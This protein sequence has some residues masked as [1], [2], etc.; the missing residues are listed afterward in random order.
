MIYWRLWDFSLLNTV[1]AKNKRGG[2]FNNII[3]M[4]DTETSKSRKNKLVDGKWDKVE[5]YVVAWSVGFI[6][7]GTE[8]VLYGRKPSE[9]IECLENMRDSMPGEQ[10]YVYFHNLAYDY[11]FLRK[12]FIRAWGE[13]VNQLNTKPLYPLFI[14][15][16]NGLCLRDSLMLAQR[17]IERWA[18][19]LNVKHKKAVGKWDYEKIRNQDTELSEDELEYIQN[20][21][22]AGVECLDTMCEQLNVSVGYLPYTN[23]GIVRREIK[24]AGRKFH[25][26]DLF[27]KC[28]PDE[29]LKNMLEKAYHGGYSHGNRD[30]I[31][32]IFKD[33]TAYDFSSSYPYVA[34]SEKFPMTKFSPLKGV[35]NAEFIIES[36]ND[37]AFIFKILINGISLKENE[38]MPSLSLAKCERTINPICDN[39]RILEA[40][41]VETYMTEQELILLFSQYKIDKYIIMDIWKSRKD[42]LP[43]W[44]RD[45]IYEYFTK[46][47]QLKDGDDPVMYQI[48]KGMLN[49]IYGLMCEHPCRRGI[50]E[51]YETG[52]YLSF[53]G[54]YEDYLKSRSNVLLYQWGV[55]ITAYA[56]VNLYKLGYCCDEWLYCDTDSVYGRGWD[57]ELI[58]LYNAE[59]IE[60]VRLSGYGP[61]KNKN[62]G[63]IYHLGVAEFD[64]YY[65]EY[66]VLGAKRYACRD[67]N[68]EIKITVSGVPKKAGKECLNNDLNN[69]KEGFSFSGEKTGKK[70]HYYLYSDGIYI[71]KNGNEC[72]DSIDLVPC[73]YLLDRVYTD[74]NWKKLF[75]QEVT[76]Q[77]YE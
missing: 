8:Y 5:N 65:T 2:S 17:K 22:L 36:A 16:G 75:T 61:V 4:A 31:G 55:W 45:K 63:K 60:K 59:C 68:G 72:A 15:Y 71:D 67:E 29:N 18:N 21:V 28:V 50:I 39:G 23:T 27:K 66:K 40:D 11:Q 54:N 33:V 1:E 74:E 58:D 32:W 14:E 34:I 51:D 9:L 26:N 10:T 30:Y 53:D 44:L 48:S 69:F 24:N 77:L 42:Y 64:G 56:Q 6:L 25:A 76:I 37:Y 57:N 38:P 46:K 35:K 41:F 19:D 43:K 12:F 20:D 52:E 7:H 49:A 3:I 13:P 62:N 47:T 73:D 70:T